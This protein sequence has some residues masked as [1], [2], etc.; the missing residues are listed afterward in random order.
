MK[1][2]RAVSAA[3]ILALA[4]TGAAI[5]ST[6][7]L[8]LSPT[9]PEPVF[10][11]QI[12]TFKNY[13]NA[14]RS[15]E[16]YSA[17]PDVRVEELGGYYVLRAGKFDTRAEGRELLNTVKNDFSDS[18]ILG[19]N[20]S[21]ERVVLPK[22]VEAAEAGPAPSI[23]PV[24]EPEAGGPEPEAGGPEAT[25][26]T[27]VYLGRR[28][29]PTE[30]PAP[31]EPPKPPEPPVEL[32]AA[33]AAPAAATMETALAA[34]GRGDWAG[35]AGIYESL[36]EGEP[37]R[38]DLWTRLSDIEAKQGD[39]DAAARA[40][41]KAAEQ[42]PNDPDVYYRLASAYAVADRPKEALGAITQALMLNPENV[43]YL[44]AHGEL[45]SWNGDHEAA[46]A[47]Y[48]LV[49]RADPGDYD[50]LLNKARNDSWAGK[51]D[52]SAGGYGEYLKKYPE[53]EKALLEYAK[54]QT[55]R[56]NYASAAEVLIKYKKLHGET[57]GYKRQMARVL[58]MGDRPEEALKI[59]PELLREAP[60]DFDLN[61]AQ[62]VAYHYGAQPEL[63]IKSHD[64]TVA[65]R[66]G[67]RE[68]SDLGLFVKTP[69]RSHIRATGRAY[70]D[71]D[72]LEHAWAALEGQFFINP[73]T[74]VT[75]VARGDRLEAVPGS[76]LEHIDGSPEAVHYR[77]MAGIVRRFD[78][79][80]EAGARIGYS[81]AEG[82]STM[83]Y[84]LS[85][86]L[87]PSDSLRLSLARDYGFYVL[88]PR[89][90]SLRIKRGMNRAGAIWSPSIRYVVVAEGGYDTF[91]D[92]NSRW[93]AAV[94][95]RRVFFRTERLN[96]DLGLRA[97]AFGF[98]HD[99]ANGYYDPELYQRYE[100]TSF[101]YLKVN[102]QTGL[103][104]VGA[105]GVQKDETMASFRFGWSLE[106]EGTVGI[107]HDW[108]LRLRVSAME[109]LRDTGVFRGY[110]LGVDLTRRL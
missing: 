109:N 33:P 95:P 67:T 8:A 2:A 9:E 65:L 76:G 97:S 98:R 69:L 93:S 103:S 27:Y 24:P 78:P 4:V 85:V 91:S 51:L 29:A 73:L 99:Y 64:A 83:P 3:L 48:V 90:V 50:A 57:P 60:D 72:D 108:M 5:M 35:A 94:A 18:I 58:S 34:E 105:A 12:G 82:A 42:S 59:L 37:G 10:S 23:K 45:S 84:N 61:Y 77:L 55:W 30:T 68:A 46:S 22:A 86:R 75:L 107:Y 87:R 20:Y 66:P 17:L 92:G 13:N 79:K 7:A 110:A 71:S 16:R 39:A 38:K 96:L 21:E 63:A 25:G 106:V 31:T 101:W 43:K 14:R 49:L 40:L 11:V 41:S 47:S 1:K 89:T 74:R 6:D 100:M 104:V 36:L 62:T 26:E 44:K 54:V 102:D 15:F 53:S 70:K 19:V 81:E 28:P 32:A 52:T 88:S 56:G 80:L